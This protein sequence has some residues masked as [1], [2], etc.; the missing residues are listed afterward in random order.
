MKNVIIL[1]AIALSIFSCQPNT[2]SIDT[3]IQGLTRDSLT[4]KAIRKVV[5]NDTRTDD[6]LDGSSCFSVKFPYVVYVYAPPGTLGPDQM[7]TINNP[8]DLAYLKSIIGGRS[9]AFQFPITILNVQHIESVIATQTAFYAIMSQCPPQEHKVNCFN[10]VYPVKIFKYNS[11]SQQNTTSIFNNDKQFFDFIN[12][13]SATDYFSIDYPVA[14]KNSPTNVVVNSNNTLR[15]SINF[16]ESNCL[17]ASNCQNSGVLKSGLILYMPFAGNINDL[18]GFSNP[19]STANISYVTDRSGN[20]NGAINLNSGLFTENIRIPLD[21][22]NKIVQGNDVSF[23]L[24]FKL[25]GPPSQSVLDRYYITKGS[26]S[27]Q[28]TFFLGSGY[29][30]Q[31]GIFL[32]NYQLFDNSWSVAL[33]SDLSTWH[34]VVVT[35]DGATNTFKIYRNGVLTNSETNST[36]NIGNSALDYFIGGNFKGSL[37]DIRVYRRLLS[38]SEVQTLYSLSGDVYTCL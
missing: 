13:L 4:T 34:H 38:Q 1:I 18:T 24:W 28:P 20:A 36:V 27:T 12:T 8:T 2:E 14:Y 22:N 30:N 9:H 11:A 10:F 21:D 37:D 19:E 5:L 29:T 15:S 25:G 17:L 26:S 3:N 23:S 33:N 7:F 35:I 6:F 32:N 31:P 16:A